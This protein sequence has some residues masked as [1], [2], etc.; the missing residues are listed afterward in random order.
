MPDP[1]VA[2]GL[3]PTPSAGTAAARWPRGQP[4]EEPVSPGALL[5]PAGAESSALGRAGAEE[6]QDG[7]HAGAMQG[8]LWAALAQAAVLPAS[9]PQRGA[10]PASCAQRL[11]VL[12]APGEVV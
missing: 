11:H 8:S 12:A 10:C 7:W 2:A 4:A 6:G 1:G 5:G 9:C 3:P